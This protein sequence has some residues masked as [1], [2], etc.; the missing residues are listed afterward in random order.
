MGKRRNLAKNTANNKANAIYLTGEAIVNFNNRDGAVVNMF[1]AIA[2]SYRKAVVNIN[3]SGE[4]NLSSTEQ[5][6]IPNL[7]INDRSKF[8]LGIGTPLQVT[9]NLRIEHDAVFNIGNGGKDVIY[10]PWQLYTKWD[11]K[12]GYIWKWRE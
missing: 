2:S 8:N 10:T 7:N 1:D 3:G 11:I 12:D 5:S 4:F 9:G 6:I